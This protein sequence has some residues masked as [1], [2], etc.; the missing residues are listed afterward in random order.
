MDANEYCHISQE[1]DKYILNKLLNEAGMK[2]F[3][4]IY[5]ELMTKGTK[6]SPRGEE[7]IEIE[8]YS[9]TLMPYYSRFTSFK[10]R[11]FNLD[12]IKKEFLWYLKGDKFDTSICEHASIWKNLINDDGSINS[13]YGQYVFSEQN[14]FDFVV[15]E[16]KKDKDS[17]RAS[18]VILNKDHLIVGT[19]DLPCTYSINF[20]IRNNALNMSVNMRSQDAAFGMT[21]DAPC[22][23]FIHEMVYVTLK[24]EYPDLNMGL[25]HHSA[26]SF[27]VYKRH[28]KML[29]SIIENQNDYELVECPK[30]SSLEE[31]KFLRNLHIN[32]SRDIPDGFEFTKWLVS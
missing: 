12:Y 20:R 16:L 24:D 11:K 18:I 8:D 30:M 25:Y 23:S 27:H 13:N 6:C 3:V 22:F 14:Q 19:K 1:I 29:E 21:N 2:S 4:E 10:D 17:R 9:Y 26:D 7:I 28:W 32:D 15:E 5:E 31:V